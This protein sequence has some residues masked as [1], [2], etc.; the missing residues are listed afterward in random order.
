MEHNVFV[1]KYEQILKA[2]GYN[3]IDDFFATSADKAITEH[4]K[5]F[6]EKV[7]LKH[8]GCEYSFFIK[9]FYH[10]HLTDIFESFANFGKLITQGQSEWINANILTEKGFGVYKPACFGHQKVLGIEKRSFFVTEFLTS[11]S[12]PRFVL[13]KWNDLS[14][15][16]KKAIMTALGKEIRRLHDADV[17]M[18]DL[19]LWHIF[20]S[21]DSDDNFKFDFIDLHRM[22]HNVNSIS[23]KAHN[24]AR[25]NWSMHDEYF[26][27]ELKDV[28]MNA[29][30]NSMPKPQQ[31][32]IKQK[33]N[34]YFKRLSRRRKPKQYQHVA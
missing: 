18:P 5:R 16:Q 11:T 26:N 8:Q 32:T 4:S 1:E 22:K 9:R 23:E 6:A 24:L 17:S 19:Y 10:S 13:D 2:N 12:L 34:A 3:T 31:E 27:D 33:V 29:Y 21:Q 25:L 15:D 30:L 20:I 7:T 28:L 14:L